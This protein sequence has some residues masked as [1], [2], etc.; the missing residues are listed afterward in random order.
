MSMEVKYHLYQ[1]GKCIHFNLDEEEFIRIWDRN[2][3]SYEKVIYDKREYLFEG[4][5]NGQ[6]I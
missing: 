4:V 5:M 2:T 3:M 1:N 6:R